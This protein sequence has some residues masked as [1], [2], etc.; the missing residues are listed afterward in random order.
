MSDYIRETEEIKYR[1]ILN[2]KVLTV[3]ESY[4]LAEQ[5]ISTLGPEQQKEAKI[6]P[7]TDGGKQVLFG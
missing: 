4:F 7:I 5:F 3:R 2:N 1:I 6:E